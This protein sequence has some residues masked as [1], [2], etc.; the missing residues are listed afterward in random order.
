[1]IFGGEKAAY[2]YFRFLEIPWRDTLL[3][4]GANLVMATDGTLI[5]MLSIALL[6]NPEMLPVSYMFFLISPFVRAA[7]DWARLFYFDRKRLE[8]EALTNPIGICSLWSD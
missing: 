3:S 4:S 2:I 8:D 5:A 7:S 1:M 6:K